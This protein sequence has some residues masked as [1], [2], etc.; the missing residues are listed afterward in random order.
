MMFIYLRMEVMVLLGGYVQTD[1]KPSEGNEATK[2]A[3][4]GC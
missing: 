4:R 1:E 2:I 3:P